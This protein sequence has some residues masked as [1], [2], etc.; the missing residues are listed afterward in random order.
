[1]S[2]RIE[3]GLLK[4][5]PLKTHTRSGIIRPTSGKVRQALFNMLADQVPEAGFCDLFAGSGAVAF[6]AL[7]RGA[8]WVVACENHPQSYAQLKANVAHVTSKGQVPGR[9]ELLRLDAYEYGDMPEAQAAFDI[10]FADPPFSQ[11]FSRLPALLAGMIK[12]D[13]LGVVQYPTRQPPDF[14]RLAHRSREYGESTLAF[15]Q[16]EHLAQASSKP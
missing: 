8:S 3:G 5:L 12:P 1:M 4:G 10:V 13:G 6:E 9:F 7:S 2:V 11:D 14:A 16:L 15:F